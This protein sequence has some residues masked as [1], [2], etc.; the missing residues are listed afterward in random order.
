[1]RKSIKK[2]AQK[3]AKEILSKRKIPS[4][5]SCSEVKIKREGIVYVVT[6]WKASD[7]CDEW[8]DAVY[9]DEERAKNRVEEIREIGLKSDYEDF[10]LN[11]PV[12]DHNSQA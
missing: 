12:G 2:W 9:D 1:M 10:Y 11:D 3:R 6:A 5:F 4:L 8:I 7:E